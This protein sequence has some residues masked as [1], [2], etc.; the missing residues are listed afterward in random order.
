MKIDNISH[1][2]PSKAVSEGGGNDRA[3]GAAPD[4]GEKTPGVG[5]LRQ[6]TADSSRDI[7]LAR[8]QEIRQAIAGGQ[9]EIRVDKIA[10]GLI[11][12]VREL[13]ERDPQ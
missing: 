9:L 12:S 5:R 2:T 7:D 11:D 8:V 13:L 6:F 4:A 1:L 10:D 3:A